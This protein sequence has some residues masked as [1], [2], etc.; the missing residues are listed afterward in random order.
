MA[1]DMWSLGCILAELLTGYA[2]LPGED[3]ADQLACIIEL[4]GMPPQSLLDQSKRA[5]NFISAKG[6]PR[7]CSAETLED[8][9]IILGP[10]LSRRGKER[11]P[12]GGKDLRTALK[13]CDDQLFL[14]FLR[15]CLELDPELRMTPSQ[16]LRH[17]WFRRRLPRPPHP[18]SNANTSNSSNNVSVIENLKVTNSFKLPAPIMQ[19]C[20]NKNNQS[21][22]GT[23]N[24]NSGGG[25]GGG[26]GVVG[27]AIG[28]VVVGS[29]ATNCAVPTTNKLRVH[30]SSSDESMLSLNRSTSSVH[31]HHH[32]PT[33]AP[34]LPQ[35]QNGN[36]V[37]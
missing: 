28:G 9:T 25:G 24:S 21:N 1:I 16:A 12:P 30:L 23:T 14:S 27:G 29:T 26:G 8:G 6:Y 11:R 7:Y 37:T 19:Y 32:L 5:K 15:G 35:I 10:G 17:S 2:L 3:E 33:G 18:N 4:L 22:S 20:P 13:G 31:R 34:K 36:T